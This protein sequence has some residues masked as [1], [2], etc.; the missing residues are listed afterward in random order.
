MVK[1]RSDAETVF[2]EIVEK[3]APALLQPDHR[4]RRV[5][6]QQTR[7]YID[8]ARA[9]DSAAIDHAHLGGS[10][11]DVHV[12]QTDILF[13]R[14]RHGA[15]EPG[16]EVAGDA[17]DVAAAAVGGHGLHAP[18]ADVGDAE[19]VERAAELIEQKLGPIDIWIN[20]AMN[21]VFCKFK[22]INPQDFKRVT[23]VTYLGQVYGTMAALKRMLP[24]NRGSIVFVGSALAYRGIPLQSAYC[25]AKH[26]IQGFFDSLR[27]ELLNEKSKVQITMVEMPALNTPQFNWVKSCLPNKPRPMGK[28]YQPEV[29]AKAVLYAATH[30]RREIYVGY[31]TYQAIIGDKIAPWFADIQLAKNGIKGQQMDQPRDPNRQNNLYEP[32]PGDMGAHGDFDD[33]A[34][35]K[36]FMLWIAMNRQI[37][38]GVVLLLIL[39]LLAVWMAFF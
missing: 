4:I 13:L 36:S 12:Q 39:L 25:G 29:A 37:F 1:F 9:A 10:A 23:D 18:R 30:N 27:C 28:I 32:V 22:E 8:R 2:A 6:R 34:H 35:D 38:W 5:V 15:G 3:A 31:P 14:Q 19:A 7:T 11:T 21:S 16:L 24:R 33:K 17:V 26:A 20:N